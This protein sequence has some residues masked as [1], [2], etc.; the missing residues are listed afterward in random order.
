[1]GWAVHAADVDAEK[2]PE[3]SRSLARSFGGLKVKKWH[4]KPWESLRGSLSHDS[5]FL[6][7]IATLISIGLVSIALRA[8]D[9]K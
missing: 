2:K 9:G 6:K 8:S 3:P 4:G 1:V 5:Q 7:P